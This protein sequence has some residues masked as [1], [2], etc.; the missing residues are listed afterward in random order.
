MIRA[1]PIGVGVSAL[2]VISIAV[3]AAV[4]ST[5][6]YPLMVEAMAISDMA[7]MVSAGG[8]ETPV[9]SAEIS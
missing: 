1:I 9:P 3:K 2:I 5:A 7:A 6:G 4:K 8:G